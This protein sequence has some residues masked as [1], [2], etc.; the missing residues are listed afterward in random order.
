MCSDVWYYLYAVETS[1][2]IYIYTHTHTHK[3]KLMF[4]NKSKLKSQVIFSINQMALKIFQTWGKRERMIKKLLKLKNFHVPIL[5]PA[6][7]YNSL[8]GTGMLV[9]LMSSGKYGVK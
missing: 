5:Q 9:I 6:C 1:E 8:E 3:V 7:L 2:H 4:L